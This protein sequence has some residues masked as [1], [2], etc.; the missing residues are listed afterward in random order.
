[1]TIRGIVVTL[2]IYAIPSAAICR[3][4]LADP[5]G[6]DLATWRETASGSDAFAFFLR[7][8]GNRGVSRILRIAPVMQCR[9]HGGN[10]D[11]A[12]PVIQVWAF[13]RRFL[14]MVGVHK[15]LSRILERLSVT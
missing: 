1:M 2:W 14:V 5:N 8:A 10:S 4:P 11:F 7:T 15:F 13:P 3:R 12:V 6:T 9:R